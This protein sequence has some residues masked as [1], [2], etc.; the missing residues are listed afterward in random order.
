[1]ANDRSIRIE[2]TG[3]RELRR[4]IKQAEDQG[5]KDQLKKAYKDAAN[6]VARSGRLKA[7][8]R[9]GDL[10]SSIRSMN[11]TT[12]AVVAAGRGR[13]TDYAGVIHYGWPAHNIT[14]QPFL[15]QA[16]KDD[17][18]RVYDTFTDAVDRVVED[19]NN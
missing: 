8:E 16:L 6:I 5:L 9:S 2:V 17:W 7:P 11:Q 3:A 18:D 12:R 4:K 15:H 10:A 13:T 19:I 14:P 1:M